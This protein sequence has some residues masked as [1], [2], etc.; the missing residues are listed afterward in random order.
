MPDAA[1]NMQLLQSVFAELAQGNGRPFLDSMADD[2]TW[3]I[4][5]QTPWSRTY[6]RK[7]EVR[8]ELIGERGIGHSLT[9]TGLFRGERDLDRP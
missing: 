3:T 1:A 8:H 5:G 9:S 7:R 4:A 2:S 6:A